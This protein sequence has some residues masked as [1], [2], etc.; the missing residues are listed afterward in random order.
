MSW[1]I[2][3][4]IGPYLIKAVFKS[5][6]MGEVFRAYHMGWQIDVAIKV[7]K[8]DHI[9]KPWM[10][11]ALFNEAE[12]WA[13]M[14][15]HPYITTCYYTQW[16][17]GQPSIIAEFV[18][19]GSLLDAINTRSLYQGGDSPAVS[20][21]LEVSAQA[22]L[23]L[24]W[25]HQRRFI[26]Q[27]VKPGNILIASDGSAKVSDFGLTAMMDIEGRCSVLGQTAPYASPEQLN[28]S[29]LTS[30]SDLWSLAATVLHMFMGRLCWESGIVAP[31]VFRQYCD[32]HRRMPGMPKMPDAVVELLE[33]C[34][35]PE[36]TARPS[37]T[38][39]AERLSDIHEEL[40]GDPLSFPD[41]D[42]P[43]L[44]ADSL[45]NRAVSLFEIGRENDAFNKL[46]EALRINPQHLEA[47]FNSG[48][49][50][51]LNSKQGMKWA[52]EQLQRCQVFPAHAWRLAKLKSLA[53]HA[54]GRTRE[55][56]TLLTPFSDDSLS[57]G[58][59]HERLSILKAL[60]Q[61]GWPTHFV[62]AP[63]RAASELAAEA[64]RFRRLFP[65]AQAAVTEGRS[66]DASRYLL[67]LRDLPDYAMHPEVIKL[68]ECM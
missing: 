34:F 28:N 53:L 30:A 29:P 51:Q 3:Q 39:F 2:G 64:T 9:E 57:S 68:R 33:E 18:K 17:E 1:K 45:N 14:A 67:M 23:G 4:Q 59:A 49:A 32:S 11:A 26:H 24:A 44:A 60:K 8:P 22:A 55:A 21:M 35:Q 15:L 38:C 37:C 61:P 66:V 54:D 42:L 56:H 48:L 31:H 7:V 19:S 47:I 27:D 52:F 40:F 43:A 62:L 36:A 58:E 65:K 41:T 50:H 16:I 12:T 13:D 5:G 46:S 6:G 63:P 20:R 10:L 25:A